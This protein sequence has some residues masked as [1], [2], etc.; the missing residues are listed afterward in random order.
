MHAVI[1]K[2]LG[3]AVVVVA[4]VCVTGATSAT[5]DKPGSGEVADAVAKVPA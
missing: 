1:R 4:L 3:F 5:R 2:C